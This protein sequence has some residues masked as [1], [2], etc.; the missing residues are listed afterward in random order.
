MASHGL[1]YRRR[2]EAPVSLIVLRRGLDPL[3]LFRVRFFWPPHRNG[4]E[5]ARPFIRIA[6]ALLD[7]ILGRI[8][9]IRAGAFEGVAKRP[10]GIEINGR[11][12]S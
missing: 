11:Q 8:V 2:I 12:Q 4:N 1:Q 9:D 6:V 3:H 10:R 7:R 5:C